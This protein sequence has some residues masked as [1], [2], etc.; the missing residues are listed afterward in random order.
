MIPIKSETLKKVTNFYCISRQ[1]A[2]KKNVNL[3]QH[4]HHHHHLS[5]Y[6]LNCTCQKYPNG[7]KNTFDDKQVPRRISALR[8][9]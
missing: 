7:K 6:D 8:R 3:Y 4:S 2:I 5:C 9:P 1:A